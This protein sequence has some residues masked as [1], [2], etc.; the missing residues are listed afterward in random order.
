MELSGKER[1]VKFLIDAHAWEL[2]MRSTAA[3]LLQTYWRLRNTCSGGKGKQTR[4]ERQLFQLLKQARSLRHNEPQY[5]RTVA[6]EMES[7][8][9]DLKAEIARLDH[10]RMQVLA[11]IASKAERLR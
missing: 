9:H 1:K 11:R 8:D 4:L 2:E 6:E 5:E 3:R 7:F 10:E